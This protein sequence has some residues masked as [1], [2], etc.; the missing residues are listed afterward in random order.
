MEVS[1]ESTLSASVRLLAFMVEDWRV[2]ALPCFRA[3]GLLNDVCSNYF[4]EPV[5]RGLQ[6]EMLPLRI[7]FALFLPV[8]FGRGGDQHSATSTRRHCL[9]L[10]WRLQ[11]S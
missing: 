1:A 3:S 6:L 7:F 8:V 2:F 11:F 4:G 9:R 5:M 10:S